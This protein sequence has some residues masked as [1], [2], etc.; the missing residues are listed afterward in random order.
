MK[1]VRKSSNPRTMKISEAIYVKKSPKK[2][3]T[4]RK[5]KKDVKELQINKKIPRVKESQ[6]IQ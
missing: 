1:S 2:S 6:L 5:R 3:V 4:M